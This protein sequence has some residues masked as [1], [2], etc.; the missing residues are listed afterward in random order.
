MEKFNKFFDYDSDEFYDEL[1][2]LAVNGAY[3][4]QIAAALEKSSLNLIISEET[5]SKMLNGKYTCW[6]E[7]ENLRRSARMRSVLER[8]RA[9]TNRVVL[10]KILK[11]GLGGTKVKTK[12][13]V[14]RRMQVDGILTDNEIIQTTENESELPPNLQALTMWMY[15]HCPEWRTI[16]RGGDV[17]KEEDL[18]V[19]QGIDITK[20]I[21]QEM[22]A[23]SNDIQDV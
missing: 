1:Y 22:S 16:Q 19:K 7:E 14:S 8:A 5:F 23:M 3:N 11:L 13:T 18:E 20:W 21:E 10:G 17:D 15:H 4:S 12:S 9:N 6:T 2:A